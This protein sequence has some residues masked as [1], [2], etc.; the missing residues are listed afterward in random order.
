[1]HST[2]RVSVASRIFAFINS[3]FAIISS[4]VIIS[5]SYLKQIALTVVQKLHHPLPDAV[6]SALRMCPA[7][8]VDILH[9]RLDLCTG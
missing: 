9:D 3:T 6:R 4:T 5:L 7:V 8:D 2:A 1:M